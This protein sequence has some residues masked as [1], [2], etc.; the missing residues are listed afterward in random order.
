MSDR[1]PP[2]VQLAIGRLFRLLSRPYQDG[3]IEQFEM[4]RR[5]VMDNTPDTMRDQECDS[6]FARHYHSIVMHGDD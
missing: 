5:I 3:D 2:I 6:G 1:P 4:V